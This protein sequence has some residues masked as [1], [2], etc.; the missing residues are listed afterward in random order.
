MT[1]DPIY[2]RSI[3]IFCVIS[4]KL[5]MGATGAST[6]QK[7]PGKIT[8][9]RDY[10]LLALGNKFFSQGI[11]LTTFSNMRSSDQSGYRVINS[12]SSRNSS[13]T[14]C[15][16]QRSDNRRNNDKTPGTNLVIEIC[17]AR[18]SSIQISSRL[19]CHGAKEQAFNRRDRANRSANQPC[20][21]QHFSSR[22]PYT[23][24]SFTFTRLPA[25]FAGTGY[26]F[27]LKSMRFVF[28]LPKGE[29]L[30]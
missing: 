2:N 17:P 27:L 29:A 8:C 6:A 7:K 22:R 25:I 13:T 24:K 20:E 15:R 1:R 23:G 12:R 30:K 19:P 11:R 28:V 10:L 18:P 5:S 21:R 4:P 9:A 26:L 14:F 3:S 16:L